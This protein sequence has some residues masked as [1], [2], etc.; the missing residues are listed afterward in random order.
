MRRVLHVN[1]Y[2]AEDLGGTEV[3][4]ARTLGLLR[5]A[6]WEARSFTRADLPRPRLTPF[7]YIDNR[8]ARKALRRVLAEFVP[9]VVH[10]HNFYHVLSPGVLVELAAFKQRTGA[11]VVMT[12][13]DYHL[14]CPNSGATWYRRGE[15]MPA[16]LERVRSW[17]YLLSRRWDRRGRT[18]S[19]MKVA[20]H[21]WNYRRT[22]RRTA[23][24]LVIS[25]S[26]FLASAIARGG[27]QA[28][29]L[30]NPN[31]PA[32][33]FGASRPSELAVVFA[34]RIE[35]EKGLVR[36]LEMLPAD[37]VGSFQVLGEGGDRAAAESICHRR[38][39]GKRV[40]FLGRRPHAEAMALIAAAHVLV[41]PSRWDE[42][43]PLSLIEALAARTNV[44]VVDRGGM[45]E[46][47]EDAGVGFRF[48]PDDAASVAEQLR[49]IQQAHTAGTLNNFD[50][51]AFLAGRN[52]ATY[53]KGIL[54]AYERKL[55]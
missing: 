16:D 54:M 50:A 47:V 36:F 17:R 3:L 25:P 29:W 26:K 35:P 10:L 27:R 42:N 28:I 33:A 52:E 11:R 39:F 18:Y 32:M 43:Y 6:G 8:V 2:P 46:I 51:S 1:D 48:K 53:L 38:G 5:E 19:I 20:Q 23:I 15:P 49:L 55:G 21:I 37:F 22:D 7:R 41:L 14:V 31:P 24:D 44:L 30:P 4:M 9:D 34:G 13:H 45:R 12:A 40:E